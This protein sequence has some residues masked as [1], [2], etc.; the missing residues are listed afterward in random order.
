[1]LKFPGVF[2][3]MA[4]LPT[5]AKPPLSIDQQ[6]DLLIERG[7]AIEDREFAVHALS[8]VSYYRLSAYLYPFRSRQTPGRFIDDAS[9]AT[10]WR[11]YRF[12]RRLKSVVLDAIEHVEISVR[13][14]LVNV[15]TAQYG[16]FAYR[17]TANFAV[18]VD[19]QRFAA[20][21]G[22]IDRETERSNEE[23]VTHFRAT[24]DTTQGLPLWM[25]AEVIIPRGQSL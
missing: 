18:P 8:N 24:Y 11:Y 17:D 9:F 25:A 23:F 13:T 6:I 5:Y 1:M 2:F 14:K 7:L 3:I 15:F 10:V 16:P 22:F 20:T 21:L 12:D 19:A 4:Q